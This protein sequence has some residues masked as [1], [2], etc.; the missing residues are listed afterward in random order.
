MAAGGQSPHARGARDRQRTC[1]RQSRDGAARDGRLTTNGVGGSPA[2]GGRAPAASDLARGGPAAAPCG[3]PARAGGRAST[4][5]RSRDGAACDGRL[6]TNGAGGSP[7]AGGRASACGR[8]RDGAARDGRLMMNGAGGSPATGGRAPAAGDFARGGPAAA[9]CGAPARAG[10]SPA[11]GGRASASGGL[12]RD[13]P[14]TAPCGVAMK[15]ARS[16]RRK[17][18]MKRRKGLSA[19]FT[20]FPKFWKQCG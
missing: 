3:A 11:I 15:N 4:C 9:P 17:V 5:R 2:T 18:A 13:G 8:S 12:A 6:T 1:V 14:A 20:A 16:R 10:G 7:A 19:G